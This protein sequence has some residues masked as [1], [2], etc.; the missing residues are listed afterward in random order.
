MLPIGSFA[1]PEYTTS[2]LTGRVT[3]FIVRSPA[4]RYWSCAAC[5]IRVLLKLIVGK[6]STFKKSGDFKCPSRC[7]SCV[8]SVAASIVATTEEAVKSSS[9]KVISVVRP[10]KAPLT[11][12][13]PM[14]LAENST[15]VCIGS[16]VQVMADLHPLL[17]VDTTV[18][19][20]TVC[21]TTFCFATTLLRFEYVDIGRGRPVSVRSQPRRVTSRANSDQSC[22][23]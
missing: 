20:T 19:A 10:V 12:M 11:V 4:I 6:W 22:F 17:V 5:S 21:Q 18:L 9:L 8:F 2:R 1:W 23:N 14:C 15:C 7:L 13:I 3:F 16:T